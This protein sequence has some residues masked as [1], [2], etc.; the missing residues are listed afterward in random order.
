MEVLGPVFVKIGVKRAGEVGMNVTEEDLIKTYAVR[1]VM[2]SEPNSIPQDMSLQQIL[3]V[4][5]RTESVYYPVVDSQARLIGVITIA[6]IKEMFANREVAGWLLACDV[7]EAV[8]DK[9]TP[10]KPLEE[11]MEYMARYHLENVP[12]VAEADGDK[13]VGMLDYAK[14]RRKV[15]AEVLHRRRAADGLT[16]ATD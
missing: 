1:D 14:V 4:F 15:S 9:T 12:V 8:V 11:V 10:D 3:D 2:D 13:L 6:D 7:A 5:S 16:L